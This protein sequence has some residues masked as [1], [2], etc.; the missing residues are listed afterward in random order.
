M[1]ELGRIDI[2][3]EVYMLLSHK[4]YPLRGHFVASLNIIVYLK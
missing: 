1:F 3:N 4:A 2:A